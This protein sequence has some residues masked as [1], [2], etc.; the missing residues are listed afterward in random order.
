MDQFVTHMRILKRS[1][2]NP[3]RATAA[4]HGPSTMGQP[5]VLD[6]SSARRT[7]VITAR[8]CICSHCRMSTTLITR[9]FGRHEPPPFGLVTSHRDER[10]ATQADRK[11]ITMSAER[12][13]HLVIS[14]VLCG[15]AGS[16]LVLGHVGLALAFLGLYIMQLAWLGYGCTEGAISRRLYREQ[17]RRA[18]T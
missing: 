13:A 2:S 15:L 3:S 5:R 11:K 17:R 12:V 7:M 8:R 14:A 10:R 1:P 6:A 16:L 4:D 18:R 9:K